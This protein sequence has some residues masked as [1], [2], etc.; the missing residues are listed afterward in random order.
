MTK[1]AKATKWEEARKVIGNQAKDD[2]I[3]DLDAHAARY[4]SEAAELSELL[5][6]APARA[7]GETYL[8]DDADAITARATYFK[9]MTRTSIGTLL[10]TIFGALV[11]AWQLF[12]ISTSWSTYI[13]IGLTVAATAAAALGAAGLYVLRHGNLLETWMAARARAETQRIAYFD[14]II[15]QSTRLNDTGR[16]LALEYFLRYQFD[17]QK[18]FYATRSRDHRASANKT[19]TIGATGAVVATIASASGIPIST[20]V[21]WLAAI[22]VIGAA[23]GAYAIGR[24]QM[25]QDRRN[26]ERYK[27][28]SDALT[29]LSR[30]LDDVRVLAQRGE[31]TAVQTFVT[32]VNEQISNEHRQWLDQADSMGETLEQIDNALK[33]RPTDDLV[34]RA[35]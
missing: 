23:I 25:T 12:E 34:G 21:N 9:W 24:E 22:S 6:S 15:H 16:L 30:K 4:D 1:Q 10:T 32:A 2:Y 8:H 7:H 33:A 14:T 31:N 26:A 35:S 17:V 27:R 13:A 3:L 5:R 11:M 20:D 19:V 28:I 29:M 18:A